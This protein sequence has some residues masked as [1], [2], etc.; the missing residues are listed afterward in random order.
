MFVLLADID[1]FALD[2]H[3]FFKLFAA[4]REGYVKV[5]TVTEVT[6]KYVLHSCVRWVALKFSVVRFIEK[7]E[8]LKEYVC[9]FLREQEEFE[10]YVKD[11][12]RYKSIVEHFNNKM[13]LPFVAFVVFFS[14]NCES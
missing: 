12:K 9:N 10:E 1:H 3:V 2:L 11:T 13:T 6:S 8:N 7:W 14:N 4:R 5:V